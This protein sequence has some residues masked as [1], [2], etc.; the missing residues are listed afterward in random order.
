MIDR[1]YRPQTA[2]QRSKPKSLDRGNTI[3]SMEATDTKPTFDQR[4]KDSEVNLDGT[5]FLLKSIREARKQLSPLNQF[6]VWEVMDDNLRSNL[7]QLTATA[8]TAVKQLEVLVERLEA[9]RDAIFDEQ[10][11]AGE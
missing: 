2:W 11:A 6:P 9:E 10:E 4:L 5:K 8:T 3:R 7:M 1:G